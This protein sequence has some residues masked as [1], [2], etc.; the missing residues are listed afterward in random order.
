MKI[1]NA[2]LNKI[3]KINETV[4][5]LNVKL[6]DN[7][8]FKPGQFGTCM[9]LINNKMKNRSYSFASINYEDTNEI[10]FCIRL[11]NKG[12]VTPFIFSL[13]EGF[14]FKI[15]GPLGKMI[16]PEKIDS[17]KEFIFLAT[18]TGVA[19]FRA[20]IRKVLSN[21]SSNKVSL[22][23]GCQNENDILF[24]SEWEEIKESNSNFNF[25]PVLSKPNSN[26]QGLK[27]YV[28]NSIPKDFKNKIYVICGNPYMSADVLKILKENNVGEENI[29]YEKWN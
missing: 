29:I 18:G 24:K 1:H 8:S 25:F 20:M 10:E 6:D 13:K 7:I 27:G 2:K 12:E 4:H 21:N 5:L 11:N 15:L 23:F 9:F 19:P 3:T 17:S 26:W 28:Q 14:E 22:Y 16:L